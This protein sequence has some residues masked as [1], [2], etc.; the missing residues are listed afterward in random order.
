MKTLEQKTALRKQRER[1]E[2][3]RL[4]AEK[5]R[6]KRKYYPIY[7][8]F[9]VSIVCLV[10]E[11]TTN[12]G[13]FMGTIIADYF[14]D[15]GS[16]QAN[17]IKTIVD[18]VII[19]F[20]GAA[21]VLKPLADRYGRKKFLVIYTLG[22]GL[23]LLIISIAHGIPGYVAG[24]ILIQFCI[25]HDIHGIYIQEC[26]PQKKRGTY[27]SLCKGAATLGLIIVPLLRDI[28]KVNVPGH[29]EAWRNVYFTVAV[30]GVVIS[31][32]AMFLMR[33]SDAFIDQRLSFLY[34]SDEERAARAGAKNLEKQK[35]GIIEGLKH[36]FKNKQLLWLG[37]SLGFVMC[38]YQLTSNY[39][40]ILKFGW[41]AKTVEGFRDNPVFTESMSALGNA[42]VNK[43]LYLYPVGCAFVQF[44]PG[45]LADKYGRKRATTVF[46]VSSILTY[47]LF[48]I[49]SVNVWNPYLLGFFIGA[50]CGSVWSFG[51]LLLL[52]TSESVETRLRVSVNTA[53]VLFAGVFY[54][55][56]MGLF[57]IAT[58]S[59]ND[60]LIAPVTLVMSMI[61]LTVGSV[62]MFLKVK[63][64]K[65]A[66][67]STVSA[68]DYN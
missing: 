56:G 38:S 9:V 14:F 59:G 52:M 45:I 44:F 37:I 51:D 67:M 27:F 50:A 65:N 29:S 42:E 54:G 26:A 58:L 20:S 12:S 66:D 2:I 61:G 35:Y 30:V 6:P 39:D 19:M 5:A 49:G 53:A 13:K 15:N 62:T 16:A 36:I 24:S 3:A 17:T 31:A 21:M 8:I 10:D 7:F 4:E 11:V 23:G 47:A 41:A 64:T 57:A 63:D 68:G 33:E 1:A 48:Y 18:Y 60:A 22:M 25:P 43:M 55:V 46:A 40:V 28:L 32:V 34:L